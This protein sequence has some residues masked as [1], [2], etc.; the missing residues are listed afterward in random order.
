[1]ADPVDLLLDTDGDLVVAV[2]DLVFSSG[3]ESVA[4]ALRIRLLTFRG[5][6]FLDLD[7]GVPYYQDLLGQKFDQITAQAAFREA[8]V[9]TDNVD[10][11][12]SLST[13]FDGA[14]RTLNVSWAVTT[15][16][17]SDATIEDSMV[18]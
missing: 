4:Q 10:E 14:T 13:S 11:I 2:T 6:W 15:T 8:I 3:V 9:G 16:F 7:N 12:L 1:M 17:D 18:I 5:E